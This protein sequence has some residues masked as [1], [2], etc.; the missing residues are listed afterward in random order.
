MQGLIAVGAS[1]GTEIDINSSFNNDMQRANI[2]TGISVKALV[3]LD[4]HC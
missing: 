3:I 2:L 4:M 1:Y